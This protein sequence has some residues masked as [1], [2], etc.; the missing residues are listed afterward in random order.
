MG[1]DMTAAD[2]RPPSRA[3][4]ALGAKPDPTP[5][6]ARPLASFLTQLFACEARLAP[7]RKN[8]RIGAGDGAASYEASE[9]ADT[10]VAKRFERVL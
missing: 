1:R 4:V 7:F 9:H 6:A 2:E 5:A 8:R 3:L 10:A